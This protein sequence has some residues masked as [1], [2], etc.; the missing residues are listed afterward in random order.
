MTNA[1]ALIGTEKQ[2][3]WANDIRTMVLNSL[4]G[5]AERRPEAA[6]LIN[7]IIERLSQANNAP[8]WINERNGLGRHYDGAT[9]LQ[10]LDM[11]STEV[12]RRM[13]LGD[14]LRAARVAVA[15]SMKNG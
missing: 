10:R 3:K 1:V 6:E 2:V 15:E 9:D 5:V 14:T 8:W 12:R 4:A 11:V 7:Q 13:G